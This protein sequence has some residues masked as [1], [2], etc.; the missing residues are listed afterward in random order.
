MHGRSLSELRTSSS[1][2]PSEDLRDH[3]EAE[4]RRQRSLREALGIS[5]EEAERTR[6]QMWTWDGLSLALCLD[7]RPFTARDVPAHE[8]LVDVELRDLDDGCAT[9]DPWPLAEERVEVRC[10][11]RVLRTA[12]PDEQSMRSDFD[13]ARPI[14]LSF[15]LR[16]EA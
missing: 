14:T 13:G 3:V 9:L 4:R 10:E 15:T 8:G 1:D 6:R 7:W 11:G 12:Y 5:S 16:R 2:G